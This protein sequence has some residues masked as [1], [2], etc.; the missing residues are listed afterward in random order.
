MGNT[1][2]LILQGKHLKRTA[3]LCRCSMRCEAFKMI[4]NAIDGVF[5]TGVCCLIFKLRAKECFGC[6]SHA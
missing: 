1:W 3:G 4:G 2:S 5:V 6:G